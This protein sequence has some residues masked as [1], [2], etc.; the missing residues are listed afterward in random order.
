MK[1]IDIS[2]D[3]DGSKSVWVSAYISHNAP[4]T[5]NDQGFSDGIQRA[6][7][8]TVFTGADDFTNEQNPKIYFN[9]PAGSR[10]QL[11]EGSGKAGG[12]AGV[13]LG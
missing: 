8:T 10:L 3:N 6:P 7:R 5:S 13:R 11:K 9:N 1:N 12:K 4:L 2:H